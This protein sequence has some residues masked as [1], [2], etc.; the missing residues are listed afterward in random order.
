MTPTRAAA[1]GL[2]ALAGYAAVVIMVPGQATAGTAYRYWAYYVAQGGSWHYS[3][4]GPGSEYPVDGEVQ[5]WRFAVQ[6]DA[7]NGLLPRAM[8]D[9]AT[10][11]KSMPAKAGELR[12]GVVIDFGLA[13]DAPAHERPPA[14]VVPGC[15]YVQDGATG[16]AVL[17]AATA[18][19]IGTGADAG[20]VCGIDG[21][22]KTECA[23]AVTAHSAAPP[24]APPAPAP[25]HASPRVVASTTKTSA[26]SVSAS[27]ATPTN[28]G[29][30]ASAAPP[31]AATHASVPVQSFAPASSAAA[32]ALSLAALRSSTRH[33]RGFPATTVAG[34]ALIVV[35]GAAALWRTRV[36]GR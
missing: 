16:A 8:P 20:L 1:L 29:A 33:G 23:V 10:I 12:V 19:R 24:A 28:S 35:L 5:G 30:V 11:C 6:I 25:T 31:T 34:I 14:E 13:T 21:Y 15:V 26:P 22:P 9:F 2:A 18:V 27:G 36:R 4:R 3:Q 7:A 17:Q 32:S